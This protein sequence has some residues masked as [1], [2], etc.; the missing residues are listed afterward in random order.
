[1]EPLEGDRHWLCHDPRPAHLDPFHINLVMAE[2]DTDPI[3]DDWAILRRNPEDEKF[4][5]TLS[6]AEAIE[7]VCKALVDYAVLTSS[8]PSAAT[9]AIQ[10][11][12]KFPVFSAL[13]FYDG[14]SKRYLWKVSVGFELISVH[15][16]SSP[17]DCCEKAVEE[18]FL[19]IKDDLAARAKK[20]DTEADECEKE[21]Y[22]ARDEARRLKRLSGAMGSYSLI[23]HGVSSS[24]DDLDQTN[25]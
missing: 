22:A 20:V 24:G 18:L 19:K 9:V 10:R 25:R 16:S 6:M 13:P 15:W 21:S 3:E 8:D 5:S 14:A 23:Q 1:M 17:Q 4:P 11:E 12:N 7:R 2:V